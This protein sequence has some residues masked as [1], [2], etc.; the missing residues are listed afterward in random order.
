MSV[1]QH[2]AAKI[3]GV[4]GATGSGKSL[5]VKTVLLKPKPKRL[6]VWNYQ[7]EQGYSELCTTSTSSLKDVATKA[8]NKA[9]AIDF[10]PNLHGDVPAQ[11]DV[12]CKIAHAVPDTTIVV[13]ELSFVTNPSWSP[14]SWR[15]ICA[16]GR[17]T[18]MTVIGLAQRTAMVDKTFY[19]M[20]TTVRCGRLGFVDDAKGMA[21][22]LRVQADEIL[23]LKPLD[24]IERDMTTGV[25]KR[26]RVRIPAS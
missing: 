12:F 1:G 21:K 18:G 11:F 26:G 7:H 3:F 4:F 17:H 2:N 9:F 19:G 14:P 5:Y 20:C 22:V 16:T 23:E 13:E 6:M 8:K 24:F 15:A 25:V 10:K